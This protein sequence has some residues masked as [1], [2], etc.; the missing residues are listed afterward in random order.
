[1]RKTRFNLNY[2]CVFR[3]NLTS[4]RAHTAEISPIVSLG[5]QENLGEGGAYRDQGLHKAKSGWRGRRNRGLNG[6][7]RG[8]SAARGVWVGGYC[9]CVFPFAP[10]RGHG[11][12][13]DHQ[14]SRWKEMK[15]DRSIIAENDE[16]E[17]PE[18]CKMR[19]ASNSD[20]LLPAVAFSWLVI[21]E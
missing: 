21:L 8:D 11:L 1:M 15:W 18:G 10:F 4:G 9:D 6:V 7:S 17:R 20:M 3:H 14:K 2:L 16:A 19:V 5:R 12:P 13:E